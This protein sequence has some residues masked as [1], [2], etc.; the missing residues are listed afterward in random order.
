MNCVNNC[1]NPTCYEE[2]FASEP[3]EDGEVDE[4]RQQSFVTCM[5]RELRLVQKVM[6]ELLLASFF[7]VFCF[8]LLESRETE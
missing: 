5:R 7:N 3:L 1:T 8:L 2:V 4:L 6:L